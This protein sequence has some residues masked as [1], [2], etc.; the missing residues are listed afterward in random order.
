MIER[1]ARL[2][3]SLDTFKL[4]FTVL[5]TVTIA[6][7]T[8]LGVQL[9]RIEGKVDAVS[10]KVAEMPG[11]VQRDIQAST[12]RLTALIGRQTGSVVP[13]S[14]TGQEPAPTVRQLAP[15]QSNGTT[16]GQGSSTGAMSNAVAV[17]EQGGRPDGPAR[18]STVEPA[19]TNPL[20]RSGQPK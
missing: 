7:L 13:A 19:A 14:P 16:P 17:P 8:F 5:G 3:G 18:A 9:N 12:D 15:S 6:G 11:L 10:I 20:Q 4:A 2:E 1:L